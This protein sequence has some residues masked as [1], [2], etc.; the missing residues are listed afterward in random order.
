M[1]KSLKLHNFRTYLNADVEFSPQHLII[2]KNNSGKTNLCS[3]LSFLKAT[4]SADL[5][6]A[7][8]AWVPGG[9]GEMKNWLLTSEPVR[10]SIQCDLAFEDENLSFDYALTLD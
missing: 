1:L 9:I 8:G 3:A 5:S 2:G 10:F 7:A 4:A 6:T